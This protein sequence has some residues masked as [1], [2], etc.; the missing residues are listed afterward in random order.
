MNSKQLRD[1]YDKR[2]RLVGEARSAITRCPEAERE[3]T[4]EEWD[5]YERCMK[6]V[7]DLKR[8]IDA[9]E[10][11]DQ[12]DVL[13]G[14][15]QGTADGQRMVANEK[16]VIGSDLKPQ[17]EPEYRRCFET[18]VR[19]GPKYMDGSEMRALE[20]GTTTEGGFLVPTDLH[21]AII[22][23]LDLFNFMRSICD[24]QQFS[25]D[26]NIPVESSVG[27]AGWVDEEGQFDVGPTTA[28]EDDPAFAQVTMSAF[29]A[30]RLIRASVELLAD[31]EVNLEAYIGR[32]AGR[33]IG[34]LE[35]AAFVNGDGTLKPTGALDGWTQSAGAFSATTLDAA[36]L[37][38]AQGLLPA[39]YEQRG[40][41]VARSAT[42]GIIRALTEAVNGQFLWRPGL[43]A[44][45]P[46]QLLGRPFFKSENV[47]AIGTGLKS[48]MIADF[49][50]YMIADRGNFF[51]QRLDELF[52]ANGQVGFLVTR[53]TEGKVT[54]ADAGRT[55]LHA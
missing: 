52:A 43:Q 30:G 22:E 53:R 25:H 48:M 46:D 6:E 17:D 8:R 37:I 19:K 26:R 7:D 27:A 29:K 11:L 41:W 40:T 38:A 39:P 24:V 2:A 4:Q 45:E 28:P 32:L 1:L 54:L 31:N 33:N 5:Q 49:S 12:E 51:V 50:Y 35:E 3:T 44:G 13:L 9:V 18:Y 36:E 14:Q 10:C 21:N 15:S 47:D 23:N 20:I 55:L 16:R 34:T 42:F